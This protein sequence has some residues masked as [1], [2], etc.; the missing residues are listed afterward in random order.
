MGIKAR[1]ATAEFFLSEIFTVVPPPIASA[2]S[3]YRAVLVDIET[4]L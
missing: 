1:A 2:L 3:A 4:A